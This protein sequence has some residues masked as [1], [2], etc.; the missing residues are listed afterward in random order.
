MKL[1]I[2]K[3]NI[4]YSYKLYLNGKKVKKF[5]ELFKKKNI[6]NIIKGIFNNKTDVIR[7]D[8]YYNKYFKIGSLILEF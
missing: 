4:G 3:S 5:S 2:I 7:I 6:F 1:R 8:I